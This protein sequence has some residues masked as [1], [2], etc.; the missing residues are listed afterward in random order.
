MQ[1]YG[2]DWDQAE[3]LETCLVFSGM[4]IDFQ[5]QLA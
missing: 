5:D 2:L 1:K 4:Q 3:I